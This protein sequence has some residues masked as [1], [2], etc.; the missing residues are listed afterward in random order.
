VQHLRIAVIVNYFGLNQFL[1]IDTSRSHIASTA[2]TLIETLV[3]MAI[4]V[5]LAAI[6]LPVVASVKKEANLSK[7]VSNLRQLQQAWTLLTS[8]NNGKIPL[9][10]EPSSVKSERHWPGRLAP[11][12]GVTFPEDEFSVYLDAESIPVNN[13][14]YDP[15]LIGNDPNERRKIAYAMNNYGLGTYFSS[16]YSG[17]TGGGGDRLSAETRNA[18]LYGGTI[19]FGDGKGSFHL[20]AE[21]VEAAGALYEAGTHD[22]LRIRYYPRGKASFVRIDGSV[23]TTNR[24]PAMDNW[25]LDGRPD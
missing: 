6:L 13:V 5:V 20:G 1:Y 9:P 14:F 24:I 11:Y 3:V 21:F 16:G 8:D 19:L 23:F 18:H 22:N 25:T 2:F 10:H 4:I 7:N 12:L 17:A 15:G